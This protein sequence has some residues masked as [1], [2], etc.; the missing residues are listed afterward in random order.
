M[1]RF[2]RTRRTTDDDDSTDAILA[3]LH[4]LHPKTIDLSLG[5]LKRLLDRL[6]RPQD[7]LPS[8]IH[9]AGTNGKGSVLAFLRAVLETAGQRVH[10]YTSPHLVR[11][12]ER[13]RLDGEP[14][15]EDALSNLLDECERANGNEQITFFEITTAAAMLAYARNP[16]DLLLLECGLG[17][18]FDATNVVDN[19]V[20]T[21]ITPVSMDHMHF[22]GDTIRQI[23]GEKAA[24]Q[25]PGVTSVIAPQHNQ[26][27]DV[28][29]EYAEAV[30]APTFLYARDWSV[31]P[32]QKGFR[33][34]STRVTL[35]LPAPGLAGRHQIYNAGTAVA[36]LERLD[37]LE[38]SD[39]AIAEGLPAT[40]W[41]GRLQHLK[42]GPLARQ[43]PDGFEL[44]LDGGHNPAAGQALAE[45]FERWTDKPLY[46]VFGMMERKPPQ[47]FLRPMAPHVRALRAIAIP[48]HDGSLSAA[49]AA[50]AASEVDIP[51]TPSQDL[52]TALQDVVR[53]AKQPARILI[54]GSL[55]LAGAVLARNDGL[56]TQFTE[57]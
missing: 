22:L 14:I 57:G 24:I 51:S 34:R 8:V 27:A 39:T 45:T 44:W 2:A 29:L 40:H 21:V 55:Y 19:P 11:F 4:R 13:I 28:I 56:E 5:R 35:D 23:A 10:T 42:T 7:H 36:C 49:A 3:R 6:G 50:E 1:L 43:L 26:A 53:D 20:A 54:C 9:I 25:K 47:N 46:L 52:D 15:G 33:Y 38:I 32:T 12:N 17:G 16:A 48:G 18:R 31:I 37:Q 30:G 41:P